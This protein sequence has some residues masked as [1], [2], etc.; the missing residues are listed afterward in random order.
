MVIRRE[1]VSNSSNQRSSKARI[2]GLAEV[3]LGLRS[4][5]FE[6]TM[7]RGVEWQ[8]RRNRED[9]V[10]L[11]EEKRRIEM[12]P[13]Y[14]QLKQSPVAPPYL[15]VHLLL[16]GAKCGDTRYPLHVRAFHKVVRRLALVSLSLVC[17]ALLSGL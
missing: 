7:T 17:L 9:F 1:T 6:T 3:A 8:E 14:K 10:L 5:C 2:A 11:I 13:G 4:R 12:Y 16:G 15:T